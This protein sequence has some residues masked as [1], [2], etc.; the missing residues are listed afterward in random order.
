MV[1]KKRQMKMSSDMQLQALQALMGKPTMTRWRR[2]N[3]AE[4]LRPRTLL[5]AARLLG[6]R[7][8][9]GLEAHENMWH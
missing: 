9:W 2:G 3:M 8:Y 5:R 1:L 6:P 7:G 4:R